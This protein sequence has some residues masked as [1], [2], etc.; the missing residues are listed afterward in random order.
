MGEDDWLRADSV[1][2]E[3]L[4]V[5]ETLT[6]AERMAFLLH[7][8]FAMPYDEIAPIVGRTPAAARQ[9]ATRARRQI[10]ETRSTGN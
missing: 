9:L 5:L 8:M 4:V 10:H 7:D 3:L 6:P 2:L 1:G